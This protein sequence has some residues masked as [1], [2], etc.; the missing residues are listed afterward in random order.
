MFLKL[1]RID[2]GSKLESFFVNINKCLE[3]VL[4]GFD[5]GKIFFLKILSTVLK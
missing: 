2:L 5:I 4:T 1:K 3:C